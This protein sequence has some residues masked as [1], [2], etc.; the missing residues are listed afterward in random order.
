MLFESQAKASD[1]KLREAAASVELERDR[2]NGEVKRLKSQLE[3]SLVKLNSAV[4]D[5]ES[6]SE[7]LRKSEESLRDFEDKVLL[8]EKTLARGDVAYKEREDDIKVWRNDHLQFLHF[9]E[10]YFFC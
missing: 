3:K 4:K 2:A 9:S 8:L 7:K 5:R 1:G 10:F 6:V